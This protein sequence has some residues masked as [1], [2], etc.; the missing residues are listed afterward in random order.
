MTY[1]CRR[2]RCVAFKYTCNGA[3]AVCSAAEAGPKTVFGLVN[4]SDCDA[5][6]AA[7]DTYRNLVCCASDGCNL[8]STPAAPPIG[9]TP[10][11]CQVVGVQ[12]DT[13]L[14]AIAAPSNCNSAGTCSNMTALQMKDYLGTPHMIPLEPNHFSCIDGRHDNEVVATPAGDMGIFLSSVFVYINR[15][16]APTDFSYPRI[17]VNCLQA[18]GSRPAVRV[19][20]SQLPSPSVL[21]NIQ[22]IR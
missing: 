20:R 16:A 17:K 21:L 2:A 14:Q 13:A 6:A 19:P 18:F 4:Q 1:L 10:M 9:P 5:L 12:I 3:D 15:T 7:P 8:D 11:A 22:S